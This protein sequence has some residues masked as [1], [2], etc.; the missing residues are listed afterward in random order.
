MKT[1]RKITKKKE[2][3]QAEILMDIT[4]NL[5]EL[6]IDQF[7][8]PHIFMN[9][10]DKKGFH[11]EVVSLNS[12]KFNA[13]LANLFYE[14]TEKPTNTTAIKSAVLTLS[15]KTQQK[16]KRFVL[17]NRVAWHGNK[18]DYDL[19]N[20]NWGIIRIDK[21]GWEPIKTPQPMFKRYSHQKAQVNPAKE[22]VSL[23]ELLELFHFKDENIKIVLEVCIIASFIP[24]IAHIILILH[25]PQGSTKS[26]F[27]K[28]FRKLID[29]SE[30]ELISFPKDKNELVQLLS[31][32]YCA[33]FDNVAYLTQEQSDILC[34]GSTGE[35][36]SKRQLFTDDEDVI[37]KYKRVIGVNGINNAATKPDLL[38]RC[39]IAG[40]DRID[41]TQRKEDKQIDIWFEKRRAGFLTYIFDAVSKAM[42]IKE[43]LTLKELPRMADFAL[44]GE[45]IAMAIGYKP[46]EFL[47]A[48]F[49]NIDYQLG[50]AIAGSPIGEA[51]IL[52]ME[53]HE[54][55]E[56]Q[57][58][59]LLNELEQVAAD[60][61]I[62][63]L[64]KSWP[65]A[66]NSLTRRLNELKTTLADLGIIVGDTQKGI[67]RTIRIV[68]TVST[69]L[70]SET[71]KNVQKQ[72][73]QIDDKDDD[74][75]IL[76]NSKSR[77]ETPKN[78]GVGIICTNCR[79]RSH[80]GKYI[81]DLWHCEDCLNKTEVSA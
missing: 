30:L 34:K 13:H 70:P 32:H 69:V 1:G 38:D 37:R 23:K 28:L 29:P 27:F 26:T 35:G 6:F 14:E 78:E 39:I 40:F 53:E 19:T 76:K 60:N 25:G 62:N 5:G 21:T 79:N 58:R 16:G 43:N 7:G 52:F 71:Q 59:E 49:K 64:A 63:V 80:K 33:P 8:Q 81:S 68:K 3:T 11:S 41:K 17:E 77:V 44:W 54:E 65:K 18:I 46:K 4:E 50:E 10:A 22:P 20:A 42:E 61:K 45:A 67:K 51:I 31:H 48:Y 2:P 66:A 56:G 72:G 12:K 24:D 9:V 47:N 55:W 74:D 36:T 57:P 15:G 73:K 75:G